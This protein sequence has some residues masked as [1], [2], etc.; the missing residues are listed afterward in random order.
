LRL[1]I[2]QPL[3]RSDRTADALCLAQRGIAHRLVE[4]FAQ[5]GREVADPFQR[6]RG[7][8]MTVTLTREVCP[9]ARLAPVLR[10]LDQPRPH[11][12]ERDI[13]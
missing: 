11:R 6:Q 5:E 8:N 2:L 13:A 4:R 1:H 12:I 9:R 7:F 10:P 3:L